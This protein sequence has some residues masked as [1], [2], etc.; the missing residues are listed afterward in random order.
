MAVVSHILPQI[1][2]YNHYISNPYEPYICGIC[3]Y[4]Y[5]YISWVLSQGYPT[6]LF[7]NEAKFL[8]F[9]FTLDESFL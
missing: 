4:I 3:W 2:L 8:G 7:L 1:A 9:I 6:F 5:I